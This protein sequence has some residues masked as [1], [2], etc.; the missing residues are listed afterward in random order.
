MHV[1]FMYMPA[2]LSESLRI[3]SCDGGIYVLV[4]S[5]VHAENDLLSYM[6]IGAEVRCGRNVAEARKRDMKA[7]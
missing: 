7:E 1:I 4:F 3:I 6:E 5:V 2:G